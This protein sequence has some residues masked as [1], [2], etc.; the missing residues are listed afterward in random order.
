MNKMNDTAAKKYD[1]QE[2]IRISGSD[3]KTRCDYH[4]KE[5]CRYCRYHTE[6]EKE[7]NL[8]ENIL[9][10]ID[11]NNYNWCTEFEWD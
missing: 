3:Y 11:N 5:S 7:R 1:E 4:I 8:P 10:K 6:C 2:M 9:Q